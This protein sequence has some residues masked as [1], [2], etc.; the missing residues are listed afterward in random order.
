MERGAEDVGGLGLGTAA[1]AGLG[2]EPPGGVWHFQQLRLV[3][4]PGT[5]PSVACG[6]WG[7][8]ASLWVTFPMRLGDPPPAAF[9][10]EVLGGQSWAP[11]D[12]R[13]A[14]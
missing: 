10:V 13:L 8:S 11:S 14:T 9:D 6:S 3:G 1:Q 5:W 4:C 12:L 7:V 2:L